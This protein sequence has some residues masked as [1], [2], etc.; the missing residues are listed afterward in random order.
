MSQSMEFLNYFEG[1]QARNFQVNSV[2]ISSH[3]RYHQN[4]TLSQRHYFYFYANK[5]ETSIKPYL[6]MSRQMDF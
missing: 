6:N 5:S 1:F 4:L 3:P 2:Q